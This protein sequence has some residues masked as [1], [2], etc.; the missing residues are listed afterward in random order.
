MFYRFIVIF[1]TLQGRYETV[2]RHL[3]HADVRDSQ[4]GL[5]RWALICLP[6][7][8]HIVS[9]SVEWSRSAAGQ[10]A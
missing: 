10:A 1:R 5:L 6:Q 9:A 2:V 7:S 3:N 4:N 8:S